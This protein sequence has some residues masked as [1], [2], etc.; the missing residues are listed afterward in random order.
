M[1]SAEWR[2]KKRGDS[3]CIKY[4]HI[5]CNICHNQD[6]VK[7]IKVPVKGCARNLFQTME[8]TF[9][10]GVWCLSLSFAWMFCIYILQEKNHKNYLEHANLAQYGFKTTFSGTYIHSKNEIKHKKVK[11]C[12]ILPKMRG[13]S[14][15]RKQAKHLK[16]RK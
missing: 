14:L 8:N 2:F 5:T 4:W 6:E 13:N 1:R 16:P 11:N 12:E 9:L 3:I 15:L 7:G 10:F